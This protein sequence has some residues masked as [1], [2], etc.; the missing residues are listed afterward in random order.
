MRRLFAVFCVAM[1]T[2]LTPAAAHAA[3]PQL[4]V[5]GARS[6][7]IK[8]R[9]DKVLGPRAR[10]LLHRARAVLI[11]PRLIKAGFILAGEGGTGVLLAH[12]ADGRWSYPAFCGMGGGSIGLQ[13]GGEVSKVMLIIMSERALSAVLRDKFKIGAQADITVVE[14]SAAVEASTTANA[15]ADI[16]AVAQGKG[17]FGGVALQ[18][19]VISAR[20]KL[21]HAYYERDV[22]V[23]DIVLHRAVRNRFADALR[24]TLA[25]P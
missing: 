13:I 7:L 23:E 1:L 24:S 22:S 10:D 11:V 3:D 9:N 16:Y 18:G 6:T 12:D 4:V 14:L 15:G 2:A 5:D 21:D 19:A 20:P 8:L 17:F 25:N